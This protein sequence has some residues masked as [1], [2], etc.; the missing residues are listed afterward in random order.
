MIFV[1]PTN[2][3]YAPIL[4]TQLMEHVT[5]MFF[6]KVP[7]YISGVPIGLAEDHFQSL[8]RILFLFIKATV[9]PKLLAKL[10]TSLYL[11]GLHISAISTTFGQNLLTS[12]QGL[13]AAI[14]FLLRIDAHFMS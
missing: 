13:K 2:V 9:K 5:Q 14:T 7:C 1:R 10:L 12:C 3:H 11:N 6:L 4:L 8:L